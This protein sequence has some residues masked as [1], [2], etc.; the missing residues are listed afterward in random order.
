MIFFPDQAG[1]SLTITRINGIEVAPNPHGSPT[2]PAAVLPAAVS[3]A[4]PVTVQCRNV[5]LGTT[6]EV[7]A[8]TTTGGGI[9]SAT[10]RNEAGTFASSTA[11]VNLRLPR[12]S[13]I[14]WARAT[15]PV[16]AG[17][18]ALQDLPLSQTGWTTG[19][20][21]IRAVEVEAVAGGGT[22]RVLVTESGQRIPMPAE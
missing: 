21:R 8:R 2:A 7:Q 10:A 1:A 13:G 22:R 15:I 6:I 11:L 18:A 17:G 9:V 19:G 5:P 4:V 3:D 14:L 16:A 12:G 20:E